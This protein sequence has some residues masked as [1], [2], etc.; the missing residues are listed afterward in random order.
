[1][2]SVAFKTQTAAAIDVDTWMRAIIPAQLFGVT[3]NYLASTGSTHNFLLYFPPGQK[4][5]AIPWDL[6]FLGQSATNGSIIAGGDI[7]KFIANPVNKRRYYG[8]VLD[9]LNKSF[10]DTFLTRWATHYSTFGVD[11]MTTS[12]PFLRARATYVRN[13]LNGVGQTAP[14]PV[15]AFTRTSA[16]TM[17]STAPFATITGDGW[18]D[19]DTIRLAGNPVPLN[20]TWTDDNSWTLQL[21]L[22]AGTH[23]YTLEGVRANGTVSGTA[24]V[25]VTSTSGIAPAA[26]DNLVLSKIHYHPANPSLAESN[27]GYTS[28]DDFE[29]L[30]LQNISANIVDLTDCRFD[31]GITYTF[32]ANT[33][34]PA[35]ERLVIP[36]RTA[37]FAM[38]YPGVPTAP[39]YVPAADL[40]ANK[41]SDSGE[42]LSIISAAGL[43][44]K[45][46]S[47]DDS[48]PWPT[49]ADGSGSA[50]VLVSPLVNPEHGSPWNWRADGPGTGSTPGAVTG[51]AFTG[52]P[53]ADSNGNGRDDLVDFAI[54][55]GNLPSISM[56]GVPAAPA[57]LFT[58]ERDSAAQVTPTLEIS[59][60]LTNAGPGAWTA[61]TGV[62]LTERTPLTGTMERLVFAVP[63]PAGAARAFIRARFSAP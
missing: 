3:D 27:A 39:Q 5:V 52:S 53:N 21:P 54:G 49:A 1:Q 35:G 56:T 19:I 36:R 13:L 7:T 37:A 46:F 33:R 62:T 26:A 59:T 61:P 9:V 50:L 38:R 63:A 58:L 14:V 4:G 17:T 40:T 18:I 57:F 23:T 8:M 6:D 25:T 47:Y 11:D 15:V 45:R 28:A 44:I 31:T 42:E 22:F 16:A 2:N 51:N 20:V 12:L 55:S 48:D 41:L 34:I 24:T 29:Y 10:N 32:A 30:E 60:D 43:D